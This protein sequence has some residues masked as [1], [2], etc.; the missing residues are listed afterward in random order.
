[1][2]GLFLEPL[3]ALNS[4]ALIRPHP[5]RQLVKNIDARTPVVLGATFVGSRLS[6]DIHGL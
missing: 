3:V 6:F 5:K 2:V 4:P 1:M